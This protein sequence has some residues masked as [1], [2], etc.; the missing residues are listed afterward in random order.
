MVAAWWRRR[1]GIKRFVSRLLICVTLLLDRS[2]K[3]VSFAFSHLRFSR[4]IEFKSSI[5][6][7]G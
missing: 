3:Y 1:R 2:F 5:Q 4:G 7:K 6:S